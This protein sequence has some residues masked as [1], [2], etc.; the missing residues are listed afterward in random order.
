MLKATGKWN[1]TTTIDL[2]SILY[3]FQH[4]LS[5]LNHSKSNWDETLVSIL[6]LLLSKKVEPGQK[7]FVT[8]LMWLII[9]SLLFFRYENQICQCVSHIYV[10]SIH[11]IHYNDRLNCIPFISIY[12]SSF[13][14]FKVLKY[15]SISNIKIALIFFSIISLI[16]LW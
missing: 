9:S 14:Y 6:C 13:W 15:L 11:L 16:W 3:P 8:Y 1:T 7:L 4:N 12:L 5:Q 2:W 10:G